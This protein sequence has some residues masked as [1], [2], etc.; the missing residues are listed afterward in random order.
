MTK[1]TINQ[2]VAVHTATLQMQAQQ[3][4]DHCDKQNHNLERIFCEL[5]EIRAESAEQASGRI[6]K[7]EASIGAGMFAALVSLGVY[8][9]TG[10]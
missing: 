3:F 10:R 7:L 5:K 8:V 1:D 6:S 9:L 2:I 4:A